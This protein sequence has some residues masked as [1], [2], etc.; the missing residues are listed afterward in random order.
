MN[1]TFLVMVEDV[2]QSYEL[3]GV[4]WGVTRE[5]VPLYDDG[6]PDPRS[7]SRGKRGIAGCF[8]SRVSV[9]ADKPLAGTICLTVG[10]KV[11]KIEGVEVLD[12][13]SPCNEL[14]ADR[15]QVYV[16]TDISP[17]LLTNSPAVSNGHL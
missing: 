12:E 5:M 9:K 17:E 13:G 3:K 7:F 10:E 6:D 14:V 4:S 2:L 15:L 1:V 16:A 11:F 8:S